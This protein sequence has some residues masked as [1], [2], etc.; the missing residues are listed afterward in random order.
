MTHAFICANSVVQ[1]LRRAQSQH[2]IVFLGRLCTFHF[3]RRNYILFAKTKD[4]WI[5]ISSPAVP[6]LVVW[7]T[8]SAPGPS[9]LIISTGHEILFCCPSC[10]FGD[11]PC[12]HREHKG[13][14]QV[15]HHLFHALSWQRW[16]MAVMATT[17]MPNNDKDN[18]DSN[19][20]NNDNAMTT[21]TAT[22]EGGNCQSCRDNCG[23]GH[24]RPKDAAIALTAA[25]ARHAFIGSCH[26]LV[27]RSILYYAWEYIE[28]LDET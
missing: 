22:T 27:G 15:P 12:L 17:M 21:L 11:R 5:K 25:S 19:S 2:K 6:F 7:I 24:H 8:S 16:A 4:R 20:K 3:L 28:N 13:L 23:G 26:F 10:R 1:L 18:E 9:R 14:R